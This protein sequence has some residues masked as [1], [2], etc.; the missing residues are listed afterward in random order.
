MFTAR[1]WEPASG[2]QLAVLQGR[3][4][5]VDGVAWSPDERCIATCS[6][7][8]SPD[9]SHIAT[10]SYDRTVGS[11]T[12][13]RSMRRWVSSACTATAS[14]PSLGAVCSGP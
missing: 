9:G 7:E 8:W 13:A 10:A 11:G 3:D 14:P 6:A 1:I 12:L 4:N 2:Q 5:W